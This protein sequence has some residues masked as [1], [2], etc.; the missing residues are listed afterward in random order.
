MWGD[1][2]CG[3][4]RINLQLSMR[5]N[6]FPLHSQHSTSY[7]SIHILYKFTSSSNFN[8]TSS[9]KETQMNCQLQQICQVTTKDSN[10][11]MTSC[12]SRG[13]LGFSNVIQCFWKIDDFYKSYRN[14]PASSVDQLLTRTYP[15]DHHTLLSFASWQFQIALQL[16][17]CNFERET[18]RS[19]HVHFRQKKTQTVPNSFRPWHF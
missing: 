9:F 7:P 10:S 14:P 13:N 2:R 12:R 16:Q 4:S 17:V 6:L 18:E 8:L 1:V 5:R 19:Q 11:N 3:F 15:C